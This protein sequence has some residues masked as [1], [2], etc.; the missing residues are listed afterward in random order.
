MPDQ[1]EHPLVRL[2]VPRDAIDV[3]EGTNGA[4]IRCRFEAGER[5]WLYGEGWRLF[6]HAARAPGTPG[7]EVIDSFT[8]GD[9]ETFAITLSPD[10]HVEVPFSLADAFNSFVS[11]SWRPESVPKQLSSGQL[12]V[13]YRL[14]RFIPRRVQL[15]ARRALIRRQGL[16]DFPRWPFDDSVARL[17]SL[18]LRCALATRRGEPLRFAWFWPEGNDAALIL[19]HDVESEEGL[20]RCVDLADIEEELGFRSSFNI[21]A[22]WYPIDDG[23]VRELRERGFEIG[24]HGVHHDRSMFSSRQTF[25]AQQPAVRKAAERFGAVGFRSPATHRVFDWLGDLPLEYDTTIPHSDPFEPQPGGCCSA[26]PFFIG[27]VVEMPY[28]IPQDHTLLTLLGHDSP[29]LWLDQVERI[30]SHHGLAQSVTHPDPGYLGD[31]DKRAIYRE[32]LERVAEMDGIWRALPREVAGWWRE[33]DAGQ[34]DSVG[35]ATLADGV[36]HI[37]PEPAAERMPPVENQI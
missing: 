24:V 30:R 35:V 6:A 13:Y 20:R 2:L 36:V 22:D 10:G 7:V 33:R 4:G 19:T 34:T 3:H 37:S 28:T 32:F 27:D 26:W 11:E 29:Q 17:L 9:G 15:A 31:R 8:T 16:P 14:K 12:D 1:V 18:F 23:I 21:V 25:E 5:R